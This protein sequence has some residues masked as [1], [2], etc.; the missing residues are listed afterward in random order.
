MSQYELAHKLVELSHNDAV[1]RHQVAR[2]ERG[3]RIPGPYWRRWLAVALG[4]P[5]AMMH[6]ALGRS[7]RQR[8]REA[9]V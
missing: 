3:R 4:I 7:R 9:L 2:W 5:A 6:R 1:N 8:L